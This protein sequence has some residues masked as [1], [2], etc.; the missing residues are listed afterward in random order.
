MSILDF[1]K[2]KPSS[3][4]NEPKP[5]DFTDPLVRN[6]CTKNNKISQNT[7][8]CRILFDVFNC[9]K[10]YKA[11]KSYEQNM[12]QT[13]NAYY[14]SEINFAVRDII[15]K[16][17]PS[18]ITPDNELDKMYA[19]AKNESKTHQIYMNRQLQIENAINKSVMTT[20]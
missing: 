6:Y 10:N 14:Q 18:Y 13:S 15:E 9:R 12:C 4:V 8:N 20:I 7:E 5:N 11:L 3:T 17:N 1:F 19:E 16:T 2:L